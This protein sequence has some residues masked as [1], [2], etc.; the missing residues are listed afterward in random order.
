MADFVTDL[1]NMVRSTIRQLQ[2]ET[3]PTVVASTGMD[4]HIDAVIF[5]LF[6]ILSQGIKFFLI[7]VGR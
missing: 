2:V 4:V 1:I 3:Y 5:L 7:K 6:F